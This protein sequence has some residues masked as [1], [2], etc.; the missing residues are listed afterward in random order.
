M[1]RV[2]ILLP[3]AP[4]STGFPALRRG[5]GVA[6]RTGLENRRTFTGTGGSNPP[7]SAFHGSAIVLKRLQRED[8]R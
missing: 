3:E 7:L 4:F 1:V 8:L 6:E 5:G 2:S